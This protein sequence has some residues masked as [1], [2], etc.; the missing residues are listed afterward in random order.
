MSRTRDTQY[1]VNERVWLND[2]NPETIDSKV[3]ESFV[4]RERPDN[5]KYSQGQLIVVFNSTG[6]YTY[7]VPFEAFERMAERAYNPNEYDETPFDAYDKNMVD[8]V[9]NKRAEN[10]SLYVEKLMT[11]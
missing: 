7:N 1:P 6:A 2:K 9:T 5:E 10:D 3:F 8:W 11:D 4:W